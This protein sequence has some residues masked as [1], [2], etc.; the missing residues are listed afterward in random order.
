M[1]NKEL[2][3][4]LA[5]RGGKVNNEILVELVV[6]EQPKPKKPKSKS[7]KPA[8]KKNM[9]TSFNCFYYTK[10]K[11]KVCVLKVVEN[12]APWASDTIKKI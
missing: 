2:A 1:D 11:A 12:T 4:F 10:V 6:N 8:E 9:Y 3:M 5:S 7:M